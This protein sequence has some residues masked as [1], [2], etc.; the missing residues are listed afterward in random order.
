MTVDRERP[1]GGFLRRFGPC[2]VV[3]VVIILNAATASGQAWVPPARVGSVGLLFQNVDHTGHFLADGSLLGGYDSVSR[4]ALLRFDYAITDR[5]S[6]TA[7]AAYVGAKYIGPEPSFFGL[8]IDDCHCWNTSWQDG[9]LTVRYNIFNGTFA[10]TPSLTYGAPLINYPYFG[11]AVVG[12]NL[13]ELR[14]AIDAG[15]RLDGITPKLSISGFYSYAFVEEVLDLS[16]DRSNLMVG[17]G[18]QFHPRFSASVDFYLQRTHGGLR[19]T[20][21]E[22]EE[23]WLQF[24]RLLKDDSFHA[25]ITLAYSFRRFDIL[26]S[27]IEFVDGTDSHDGRAITVGIAMPFQF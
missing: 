23:Q 18:Y 13:D 7:A 8:E 1:I 27:Y 22:T 10:L 14:L 9:S 17:V 24:D 19:S 2:T 25:G 15:G 12:R 5:F 20:E 26:G 6:I 16:I 3:S 4:G 21:F 11:E